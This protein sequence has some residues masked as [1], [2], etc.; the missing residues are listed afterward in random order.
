MHKALQGSQ[1]QVSSL[2]YSETFARVA[3]QLQQEISAPFTSSTPQ[4][5]HVCAVK[6]LR[7]QQQVKEQVNPK[8]KVQ[9]ASFL[10]PSHSPDYLGLGRYYSWYLSSLSKLLRD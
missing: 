4:H 2:D 5:S 9:D 1:V 10:Q 7:E 6:S 8:F 3:V